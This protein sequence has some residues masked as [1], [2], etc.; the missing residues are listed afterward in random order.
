MIKETLCST[1]IMTSLIFS[2]TQIGETMSDVSFKVEDYNSLCLHLILT[3]LG[4]F[5]NFEN[6]FLSYGI[7]VQ[8][9]M[10]FDN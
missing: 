9:H 4:P 7:G 1:S 5:C 3:N 6:D 10:I 2:T 8:Y